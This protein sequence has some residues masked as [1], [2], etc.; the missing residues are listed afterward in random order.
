MSSKGILQRLFE[1]VNLVA[2]IRQPASDR[3]AYSIEEIRSSWPDV[4]KEALGQLFEG[5]GAMVDGPTTKV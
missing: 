2:A 4:T 5:G 1:S 3:M